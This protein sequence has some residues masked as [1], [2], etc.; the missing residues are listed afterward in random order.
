MYLL[1][2]GS[3]KNYVDLI[4]LV[5]NDQDKQKPKR[6]LTGILFKVMG[7]GRITFC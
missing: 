3:L 5:S 1:K 4:R 6:I 7:V 2:K